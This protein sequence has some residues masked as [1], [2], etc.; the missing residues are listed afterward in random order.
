MPR[1]QMKFML[2]LFS[3]KSAGYFILFDSLEEF[4]VLNLFLNRAL[5]SKIKGQEY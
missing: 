5:S 4:F 3:L 1:I 2:G